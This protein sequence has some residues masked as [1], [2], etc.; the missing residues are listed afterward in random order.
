M[1]GKRIREQ[2][3]GEAVVVIEGACEI[4]TF[5]FFITIDTYKVG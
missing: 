3:I 2:E 5:P 1:R 4:D